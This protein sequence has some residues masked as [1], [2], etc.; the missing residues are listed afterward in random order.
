MDWLGQVY[1]AIVIAVD[2]TGD[3]GDGDGVRPGVAGPA[4][5]VARVPLLAVGQQQVAPAHHLPVQ[6]ETI[7]TKHKH[8][9]HPA[10]LI[11]SWLESFTVGK[12]DLAVTV[13]NSPCP[14]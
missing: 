8:N 12:Q 14:R 11:N 6:L 4:A 2:V 1:V 7:K 10:S 9:P 13:D 3:D 5:V